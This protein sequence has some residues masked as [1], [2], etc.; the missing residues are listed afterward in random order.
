MQNVVVDEF[1][2]AFIRIQIVQALVTGLGRKSR[3]EK[4][5][6]NKKK[7]HFQKEKKK[8]DTL[9]CALYLQS[10]PR[11]LWKQYSYESVLVRNNKKKYDSISNKKMEQK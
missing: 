7:C 2:V 11:Q 8:N 9:F 5:N 3:R 1:L 4:K 6:K 10:H